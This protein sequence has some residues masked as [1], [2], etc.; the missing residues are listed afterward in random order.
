MKKQVLREREKKV[1]T[2]PRYEKGTASFTNL[3]PLGHKAIS[4]ID[5]ICT[6]LLSTQGKPNHIHCRKNT[7]Q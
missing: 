2:E 3:V 6:A 7:V 1:K 5:A 4:T